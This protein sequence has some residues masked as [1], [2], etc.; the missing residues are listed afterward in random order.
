MKTSPAVYIDFLNK[1]DIEK[2]SL[3]ENEIL[4]SIEASLKMQG[5][6]ETEIEGWTQGLVGTC[7]G[8]SIQLEI[9]STLAYGPEGEGVILP[10]S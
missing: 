9:P 5:L 10:E 2:L 4:N 8:Q 3:T 6:G 7:P 1:L